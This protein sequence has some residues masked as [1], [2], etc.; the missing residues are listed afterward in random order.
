MLASR[1]S[2]APGH[3]R[4]ARLDRPPE[5]EDPIDDKPMPLLD[6]LIELRRRLM[7]SL[8]A[9]LVGFFVCYYFSGAIYEFLAAPLAHCCAMGGSQ[10]P[11]IYTGFTEGF[12]TYLKVA[13]FGGAVHRLPDH[14]DAALAVRGARA[15]PQREAGAAAVPGGHAGAVPDGRGAGLLLH[16]S[17]GLELLRQLPEPTGAGGLPIV[18]EARVCEYLDLVM[19]LVF[20]FGVAFQLPVALTCWPRSASSRRRDTVGSVSAATPSVAACSI[21]RCHPGAGSTGDITHT[22]HGS[23]RRTPVLR[24]ADHRRPPVDPVPAWRCR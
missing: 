9:F 2:Y 12:F 19:K 16:L 4:Q 5:E 23:C 20:A 8:A 15:V 18:L 13:M 14:R 10:R 3:S 21:D 6:H 7:W 11:M 24:G 22:R 1:A 17:G